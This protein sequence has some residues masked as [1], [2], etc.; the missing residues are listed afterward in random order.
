MAG[1]ADVANGV[2]YSDPLGAIGGA[3]AGAVTEA[4]AREIL[5]VL[6]LAMDVTRARAPIRERP[7]EV[8]GRE[9][10]DALKVKWERAI[11]RQHSAP[12]SDVLLPG[13]CD[14]LVGRW[15]ALDDAEPSSTA[16]DLV[17]VNAF[18]RLPV[19]LEVRDATC[20][21]S[22]TE[23]LASAVAKAVAVKKAW[24]GRLRLD[25]LHALEHADFGDP[26]LPCQL[27]HVAVIVAAPQGYW[28]RAIGDDGT[29]A[30]DRGRSTTWRSLL[31]FDR[32]LAG[33]GFFN[34]FVR[35]RAHVGPQGTVRG[36]TARFQSRLHGG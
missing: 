34:S 29:R 18:D 6:P 5:R 14:R 3:L 26:E 33:H 24:P 12:G 35:L 1:N 22:P 15:M 16:I 8:E 9:P 36:V 11:W 28:D 17:G 4:E 19:V 2:E 20:D 30:T 32:A 27:P 23:A 25:W 21:E 10:L 13:Y 7:Y 31:A